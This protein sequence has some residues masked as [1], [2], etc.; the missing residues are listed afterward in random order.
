MKTRT[1]TRL[2][3]T[4]IELLVVIA[5]IGVLIGLLLPAVQKVREAANRMK[6]QNNLKQIAIACM[7]YESVYNFMPANRYGG[8]SNTPDSYGPINGWGKNSRSW[9]FLSAILPQMEQQ[10]LYA[11][12]NI[13]IPSLANS[14]I[15][16]M[17]VNTFLCPSDLAYTAG[18][19]VENT[20]YTNDLLVGLTNYKGVMGS[21]YAWG[22]W[23]N[24]GF[25]PTIEPGWGLQDPWVNGDGIFPV[26]V[27][28]K[29]R[30]LADIIDG[31]S[32]T[33]MIGEQ[34]WNINTDGGY[35]WVE[36]V[37]SSASCAMPPNL[38]QV[39]GWPDMYGFRSKHT[40]GLNF[41][42][43]DGSVHFIS[44]T[45]GLA[46]YRAMGTMDGGEVASP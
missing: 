5:I 33:F 25:G 36:S 7:N 22:A 44:D 27:Y 34:A 20:I 8:Y 18:P 45:I 14:G 29:P 31:T 4:L 38:Q 39:S 26:C 6:C 3:F 46:T 35:P 19:Q 9:S 42:Y 13:P 16:A 40:G 23:G 41:A 32:N 30:R 37:G 24:A 11:Q 12:G 15:A 28:V 17:A 10:A 21:C 2:A 1:H 43:A